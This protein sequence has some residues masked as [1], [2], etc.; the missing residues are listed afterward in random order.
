MSFDTRKGAK[1]EK[2]EMVGSREPDRR[3][4]ACGRDAGGLTAL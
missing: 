3:N 4:R 2:A 1:Y